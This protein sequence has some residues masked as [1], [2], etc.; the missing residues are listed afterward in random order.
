M[1]TTDLAP[2]PVPIRLLPPLAAAVG[3]TVVSRFYPLLGPLLLALVVGALVA[4]SALAGSRA[5]TGHADVTK[6]LLRLGVVLIGLKLPVGDIASIGW[7]GV[8]VVLATVATTFTVTRALGAR[9][10]LDERFVT[11]LA[12]GFSICGAAA[13]AAV[14][15]AVRAR[16]Q[17]VALAVAMVTLY[18]SGMIVLGAVGLDALGLSSLQA[19]V[20]AGRASTR[21]PRS[22][23]PPR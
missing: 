11:C 9:L 18:G 6:Q 5:L 1:S 22:W 14:N 20:W 4:N 13:I 15:D 17:D 7:R 23:R 21:W 12:A 10:G 19:A 2:T 16:Q 3:V 8:L